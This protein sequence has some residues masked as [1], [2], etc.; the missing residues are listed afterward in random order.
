MIEL[1]GISLISAFVAG[2]LMFLA[3]CTLPL[4]PAYLSFISGVD[5]KALRDPATA[6]SARRKIF[7]NGAAFIVGFSVIFILFGVLAGFLGGQVLAP[8]RLWIGRIG[9]VLVV[10]FGIYLIASEY[11]KLKLFP[12]ASQLKVPSFI[13]IGTPPSSFVLGSTFAIAWTPCVGPILASILALAATQS[14]ALQGGVLLAVFS[15]GLAIPFLV[16][17]AAI[18]KAAARI[19]K[20]TAILGVIS[21]IGG[22]FLILLGILMITDSFELLIQWGYEALEFINY[23]GLQEHL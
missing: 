12:A 1:G 2:L 10:I 4:V 21:K 14:G 11:I 18:S 20:M 19:Q 22:V 5:E 7:V 3:P 15:L 9:G 8:Y 17:S 6:A 13:K 23:E 16:I